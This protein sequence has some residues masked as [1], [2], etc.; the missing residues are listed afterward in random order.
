MLLII[1]YFYHIFIAHFHNLKKYDF[2][3]FWYFNIVTDYQ[4]FYPFF[5]KTQV[6]HYNNYPLWCFR[7]V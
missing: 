5:N 7:V 4:F 1:Y 3:I 6:K 2:L